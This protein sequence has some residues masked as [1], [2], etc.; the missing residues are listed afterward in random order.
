MN[1]PNLKGTSPQVLEY[2]EQLEVLVQGLDGN[3]AVQFMLSLNRKL[4]QLAK[5][6]DAMKIDLTAKDDKSLDRFIKMA[7][8]ARGWTSDFKSFLQEYGV[9]VKEESTAGVPLM[10]RLVNGSNKTKPV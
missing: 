5:D 8:V 4:V 10:E 7:T 9:Q 6:L 2:I 3:G 1:R